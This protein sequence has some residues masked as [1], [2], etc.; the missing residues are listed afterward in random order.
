MSPNSRFITN[1]KTTK[2]IDRLNQLI[3][4]SSELKFLVGFFYFSGLQEIYQ[5]LKANPDAVIKILVGLNVDKHNYGIIEYGDNRKLDGREHWKNFEYSLLNAFDN[6]EFDTPEFHEQ[7][8][9]FIEAII[10]DR[11]R[12]RKTR[13]PN[14]AKLYLFGIRPADQSL[15]KSTFIT[16][17]SNLTG[18]GLSQQNEFNVEIKDY[19]YD[20]AEGF[21][22]ELWDKAVKIT[23]DD[24]NKTLLI[25]LITEKT[26]VAQVTPYEAYVF[27]LKMY[28]ET[29]EQKTLDG[30]LLKLLEN[31]GYK[32]Y[33]YQTDAVA[34]A[35]QIIENQQGVI[36]S[37]VVGLGKSIIAGLT[38]VGLQSRRGLI[39]CPP[40]LIG[41]YDKHGNYSGWAKYKKDFGLHS[42][43][44][45]SSGD[46]EKTF[47]LV[48][49]HDDFDTVIIDEA[50]RFRNEDTQNYEHL[51]NICRG[52]RVILLSATP[53]NNTPNDIFALLKLFV[54]PG[55]STLSI[56][57]NLTGEFRS[58]HA[59]FKKLSDI[60]KNHKS[61]SAQKRLKARALYEELFGAGDIDLARVDDRT[62][63]LSLRIKNII[64]PVTIRRNRIDLKNDP[65]YSKEMIDLPEV[66]DPRE[67]FFEL[68]PEQSEFYD[69]IIDV[70][71]GE[72]GRFSGAIYRPYIY[73]VG[74]DADP[75][76]LGEE[77]N[78]QAQAQTNLYDFMRRLLVKRF[79]SSFGAFRDS[80]RNFHSVSTKARQ[81]IRNNGKFIL[82]RKLLN[83]IYDLDGDLVAGALA[84]FEAQIGE[85]KINPKLDKIYTIDEFVDRERFLE[86]IDND[87]SLLEL[88]LD[89][90]AELKLT[91]NDPKIA[92]L[93]EDIACIT[94][95]K[96]NAK[97]PVRKVVIFSEYIDTV[98]Y[99]EKY[100][101]P[102]YGDRL[103]AVKGDYG[104]SKATEILANFDTT[105][106]GK[107][108]DD[109]QIL[110]TTDKMSEG[111]NLNRAGAVI[112]YD[113]PWNPTRVIQRVGRINRISRKVFDK[114]YIYNFF[115]TVQGATVVK[116]RL[117]ATQ[118][119]FLI[120]N[121]LGED[122]KIFEPEEEPTP[123]ELFHRIQL[124]PESSEK[125]SF[126]TTVR[127]LYKDVDDAVKA[128]VKDFPLRLKV[129]KQNDQFSQ[130]AFFSRGNGL[131]VRQLA[132][133]DE[134]PRQISFQEALPFVECGPEEPA[135]PVVTFD[136]D[137]Y[138]A[139]KEYREK[140]T[141]GGAMKSFE[142][143]A[144]NNLKSILADKSGDYDGLLTFITNLVED[145]ADYRT[146]PD[147]TLRELA[148]LDVTSA[149]KRKKTIDRLYELRYKL[150]EK[151]L[152]EIKRRAS[153]T[154]KTVIVAV[155]NTPENMVHEQ[156]IPAK[157]N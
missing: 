4:H 76:K 78:R 62:R 121:A 86:D 116:S 65:E 8:N 28:L 129:T 38:A 83:R 107:P 18:A 30:Y 89:E 84:D 146:L 31:A 117:I 99:V 26:Q 43:E 77:G 93:A 95:M 53:F 150:G 2:L 12:I 90:L 130:T 105:Y 148:S 42:W 82:D 152:D 71:F 72:N 69:R 128:K 35:L 48:Q 135:L 137:T 60:K 125:E 103:I 44:I 141:G 144:F 61:P 115:P 6:D 134:K 97:E 22:N 56:D 50:H 122:A 154:D 75:D 143:K 131:F 114:L 63:E 104:Q 27:L 145:I 112:N 74:L 98:A 11:L 106:S 32:T 100:L 151:Y 140:T 7:V 96:D 153:L 39:I 139:L 3:K 49:K 57:G 17:S 85:E 111:F 59:Q 54:V 47:N 41:G 80:I 52:R 132:T 79:E 68:T 33:S 92:R 109:I 34:Q 36:I 156:G 37:D 87:I 24:L 126:N 10:N 16:G 25:K 67:C 19:G 120:H 64:A 81:F 20:E 101:R 138:R 119:M 118:K 108:R 14:H 142:Q 46:L 149:S 127:R 29:Q 1:D 102:I 113:I 9:F 40:G 123:S 66:Q 5:A 91:E 55:K 23:E 45:C 157:G 155:Q 70:Y 94:A 73:E 124:N 15:L 147:F 136:W 58:F 88:V 110:L 21:F 13:E 51:A 133:G